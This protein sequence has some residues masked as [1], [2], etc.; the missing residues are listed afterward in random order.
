MIWCENV[1]NVASLIY[2]YIYIYILV[3]MF[4]SWIRYFF[5]IYNFEIVILK[6]N[7]NLIILTQQKKDT[8][9]TSSRWVSNSQPAWFFNFTISF[10]LKNLS[11]I[12]IR[13]RIYVTD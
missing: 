1:G 13:G 8:N 11:L 3:N 2:I 6:Y 9:F 12:Y 7:K 5:L 4:I 10:I